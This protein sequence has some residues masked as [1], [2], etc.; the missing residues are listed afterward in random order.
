[1]NQPGAFVQQCCEPTVPG[2]PGVKDRVKGAKYMLKGECRI[3]NGNGWSCTEHNKGRCG[4]CFVRSVRKKFSDFEDTTR[5]G[6]KKVDCWVGEKNGKTKPQSVALN[7]TK[8]FWFNCD[9]CHHDFD[10]T[11]NGIAQGSWCR[12]CHHE[13][14]KK[15]DCNHCFNRS[16][17]GYEYL[18]LAGKKK[19]DCWSEQNDKPPRDVALNSNKVFEFD[20]D[21]CGH[22]FMCALGN[23]NAGKWCPYCAVP[24][25]KICDKKECSFC[26][27]NSHC[28]DRSFA[29][30]TGC[31]PN[32]KKKVD[33]WSE[34]NDKK[35]H[36][37]A[38][39][40]NK[41]FEFDCDGCGHPFNMALNSVHSG[42]WCPYC[43]HKLCKKDDCN[44]C[45]DRSFASCKLLTVLGRKKIDCWDDIKNGNTKPRH[46]SL[47]CGDKYGFICDRCDHK[48][49][50]N[51][52]NVNSLH[53]CPYCC[54]KLCEK[55]DCNHCFDR[56]FASYDDLTLTGKKKVDC[57]S[58]KNGDTKPWNVTKCSGGKYWFDCDACHNSFDM[59]M[60]SVSAGKWCRHCHNKTEQKLLNWLT[61][62]GAFESIEAQYS[63][64]WCSTS[65]WYIGKNGK[66][67]QSQYRYR[68]DFMVTCKDGKKFIIELDGIQ[69]F[70][71]V[72]NWATPFQTQ[73]RD[74][75][76]ERVAKQH[77]LS[78][79]RCIQEDV[80]RD[81]NHWEKKL[82]GIF[83][84]LFGV[85]IGGV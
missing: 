52:A 55:D 18:T 51:L 10:T 84:D 12:F 54:N 32:G 37:V 82:G 14:C 60:Y 19:V 76:K 74:A 62:L 56:S 85:S 53:W 13:L 3:W 47:H 68:F 75:Y 67:V 39:Q 25:Q 69:H 31:T 4:K 1:M 50:I 28:F 81:E 41:G 9:V 5:T 7:S 46:V 11:L 34:Q 70:R 63:P 58:G 48:F 2:L 23:V 27:A 40:C 49:D 33:C 73:I 79:V 22:P 59:R 21:G 77:G 36:G 83:H 20:C 35:P 64:E 66:P 71:Q 45:F 30:Y 17:A 26:F 29:S 43:N 8:T 65:Y 44:H 24:T 6:K 16:F 15:D 38:L 80:W 57:W 61:Q 72:M 78:V 42:Q